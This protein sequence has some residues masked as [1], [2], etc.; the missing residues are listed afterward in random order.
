MAV[1]E[2]GVQVLEQ[3]EIHSWLFND[4]V[5][6]LKAILIDVSPAYLSKK[7]KDRSGGYGMAVRSSGRN[8]DSRTRRGGEDNATKHQC[9]VRYKRSVGNVTGSSSVETPK[10][11]TQAGC[12]S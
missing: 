3:N 10:R 8:I 1:L 11:V 12:G 5:R 2:T 9:V 7:K 4:E 6:F